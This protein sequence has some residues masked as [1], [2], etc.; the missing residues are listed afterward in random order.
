[1]EHTLSGVGVIDKAMA[2]IEAVE[3][4]PLALAQLVAVTGQ[5]RATAHRL[6]TALEVHGMLRRDDDG[7]FAIGYRALSLARG[8]GASLPLIDAARPVLARLRD[9]TGES[10]QLFVRD[11]DSRVCVASLESPHGLRTIVP[12]GAVLP[13]DQGSGGRVLRGETEPDIGFVVSVAEREAG[14]ASVSAPVV[15]AGQVVAAVSV[16]GPIERMTAD[17][18]AR[19]GPPVA[20]AASAV[21]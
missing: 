13:L 1:M 19:F 4:E 3:A 15:V 7:R 20:A 16:S 9:A 12:N 6:A 2:I 11:G 5:S 17:P 14:V 8:V 18:G 10:V 21:G